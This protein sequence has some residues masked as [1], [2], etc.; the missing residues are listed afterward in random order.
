MKL[1]LTV[2]TES[3]KDLHSAITTLTYLADIINPESVTLAA[4][5]SPAPAQQPAPTAQFYAAPPFASAFQQPIEQ[6]APA[7]PAPTPAPTTVP[8]AAAPTYDLGQLQRAGGALTDMGKR[9]DVLALMAQF[10]V[11][12]MTALP[13]EQYPAFA[14]ALRGLGAQL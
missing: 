14:V 6:Y 2:E 7:P 1:T 4:P 13:K 9:N 10:G 11:S 5:A 3:Q 8:V 12:A